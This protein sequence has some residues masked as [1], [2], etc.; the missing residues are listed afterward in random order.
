VE[1]VALGY[2]SPLGHRGGEQRSKD[3]DI[4]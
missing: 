2:A 4:Y 3:Y 1:L